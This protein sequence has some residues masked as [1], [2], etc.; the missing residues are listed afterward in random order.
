MKS[1]RAPGE[2]CSPPER[3]SSSVN[4]KLQIFLLGHFAFLDP[5]SPYCIRIRITTR[6]AVDIYIFAPSWDGILEHHIYSRFL[7]INST[8]LRL[9][10]LSGFVTSFFLFTK[11]YSRI[12]S[13]LFPRIFFVC[14]FK[15]RVESGKNP[16]VERLLIALSK[17][18]EPFVKLM[19]KNFIFVL[20][21]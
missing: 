2:V 21:Q 4:V 18:L 7:G 5:D 14:I 3:T 16:P 12:G 17:R 11:C 1:Y 15:T 6:A 10:S 8:L 13:S 20:D 9:E 19:S